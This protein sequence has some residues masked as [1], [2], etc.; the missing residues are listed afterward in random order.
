MFFRINDV[1]LLVSL[2]EHA[3]SVRPHNCAL[4]LP[5]MDSALRRDASVLYK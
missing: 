5:S 3:L 2:S 1:L 4:P